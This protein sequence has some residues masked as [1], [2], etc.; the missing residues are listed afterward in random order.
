MSQTLAIINTI[1]K[2]VLDS[3]IAEPF[4]AHEEESSMLLQKY[5]LE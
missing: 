2:K 1:T 3:K 4:L 5:A